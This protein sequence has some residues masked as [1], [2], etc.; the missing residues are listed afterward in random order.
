LM[1]TIYFSTAWAKASIIGCRVSRL[2]FSE[3]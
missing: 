1:A 2:T 3:A